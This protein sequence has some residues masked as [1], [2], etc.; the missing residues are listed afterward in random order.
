V[1]PPGTARIALVG[2]FD[3]P[4][5]AGA[6]EW[7]VLE[8]ELAARLP[9]T[10]IESY[11]PGGRDRPMPLDDGRPARPLSELLA[12]EPPSAVVLCDALLPAPDAAVVEPGAG[13]ALGSLAPGL[14]EE[15]VLEQRAAYLRVVGALGTGSVRVGCRGDAEQLAGPES[16]LLDQIAA[17]R[18]AGS[19]LTDS[20]AVAEAARAFS[21]TW[22]SPTGAEPRGG[23]ARLGLDALAAEIAGHLPRHGEADPEPGPALVAARLECARMRELYEGALARAGIAALGHGAGVEGLE[24]AVVLRAEL[25]RVYSSRSWRWLAPLRSLNGHLHRLRR[26]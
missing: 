16:P 7:R 2:R 15:R 14:Y 10:H 5:V 6:L 9:G 18:A 24:D 11:A 20:P 26:R 22:S 1:R 23:D 25:M 13:L 12:G 4:D 3:E 21:T 8:R 19:V 17:I